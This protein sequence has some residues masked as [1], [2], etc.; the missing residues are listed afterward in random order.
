MR[1]NASAS[2]DSIVVKV[3]PYYTHQEIQNF[4][5]A[6]PIENQA[7]IGLI[8]ITE[9]MNKATAEAYYH[10]V[11]FK[12]DTKEIL[13][14]ERVLGIAGGMGIRNYW[15]GSYLKVINYIKDDKYQKWKMKYGSSKPA[16]TPNSNAPKW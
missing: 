9:S 14:Q 4:V 12:M 1:L 10:V 15:A 3:S 11:F 16:N 6:Y 8:F 13:L 7:G 5:S 2:V